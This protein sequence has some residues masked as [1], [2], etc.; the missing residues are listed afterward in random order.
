MKQHKTY[1]LRS[2]T[3]ILFFM[4]S[5]FPIHAAENDSISYFTKIVGKFNHV[6]PQEKLYLHLDNT[7][8]FIGETL[9]FKVYQV[10]SSNDSLGGRS[11]IA[12]VELYNTT[13]EMEKQVKVKLNHGVGMGQIKLDD[14][15]AV[16]SL[17][18]GPT[19]ATCSTG[20]RTPYS[21]EPYPSLKNP[22]K[23][24]ITAIPGSG[25]PGRPTCPAIATSQKA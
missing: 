4:V 17:R 8:Y 2:L 23:K 1:R 9:W 12:Y 18:S 6:F 21:P 19:H 10:C 16:V 25:H 20:A 11:N 22:R 24:E 7:G 13:G 5:L 14:I 15:L 3:T